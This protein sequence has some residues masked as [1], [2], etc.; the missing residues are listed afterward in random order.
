M[1]PSPGGV[2]SSWPCPVLGLVTLVSAIVGQ[3]R[4]AALPMARLAFAMFTEDAP[5]FT[6]GADAARI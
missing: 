4:P 6:G 3:R 5:I 1:S 2:H